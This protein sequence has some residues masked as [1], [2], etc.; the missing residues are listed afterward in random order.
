MLTGLKATEKVKGE[1]KRKNKPKRGNEG[2]CRVKAQERH[3]ERHYFANS[4]KLVLVK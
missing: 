3:S 2:Q 4:P 1:S